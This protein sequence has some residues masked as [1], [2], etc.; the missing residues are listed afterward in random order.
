MQKPS[1]ELIKEWYDKL[2]DEGFKDVEH[3]ID[4]NGY[5][6]TSLGPG[7][8]LYGSFSGGV[9]T[10]SDKDTDDESIE[11]V[12]PGDVTSIASSDR[13]EYWSR[14]RQ[15]AQSIVEPNEHKQFLIDLGESGCVIETARDYG[16]TR[17]QARVIVDRFVKQAKLPKGTSKFATGRGKSGPREHEPIRKLT[18]KEIKELVKQGKITDMD[19]IK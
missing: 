13:F 1:K 4:L 12:G 18:K 5:N 16:M 15:A 14:F 19:K 17:K 8:S 2:K 6:A 11:S 3:G 7:H 10:Y 9:V